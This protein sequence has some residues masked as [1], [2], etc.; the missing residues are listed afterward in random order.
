MISLAWGPKAGLE[1]LDRVGEDVTH[2]DIGRRAPGARFDHDYYDMHMP[3]V[4]ARMGDA[5][6]SYTVDKGLGGGAPGAPATYVGMCHI[7][8]DS[9]RRSRPALGPRQGDHGRQSR[10][11]PT[12]PRSCRS[13]KSSSADDAAQLRRVGKGALRL[14]T[15]L[16]RT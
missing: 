5:C 14:P 11:T 1:R 4:K 7:F 16:L 12:S 6:K 9:S 8:A 15:I 2:A 3:L 10:T 13:A